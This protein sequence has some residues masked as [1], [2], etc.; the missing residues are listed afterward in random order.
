MCPPPPVHHQPCSEWSDVAAGT[1]SPFCNTLSD[2]L[3]GLNL[4]CCMYNRAQSSE[5]WSISY[6]MWTEIGLENQWSRQLGPSLQHI[7]NREPSVKWA[8]LYW[9]LTSLFLLLALM[10][11]PQSNYEADNRWW[12]N[13]TCFTIRFLTV[14]RCETVHKKLWKESEDRQ[15]LFSFA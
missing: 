1:P 7:Y 11:H 10:L 9:E 2:T 4:T 15:G 3:S 14:G 13:A 6:W 5:P 12:E 8:Q